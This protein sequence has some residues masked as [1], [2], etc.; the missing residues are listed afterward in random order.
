MADDGP[1]S[2]GTTE[3]R[4]T[5]KTALR[6]LFS[7]VAVVAI[8]AASIW[9]N[10]SLHPG[11]SPRELGQSMGWL[12]TGLF[13]AVVIAFVARAAVQKLSGLTFVTIPLIYALICSW[14]T[15]MSAAESRD[16]GE[17]RDSVADMMKGEGAPSDANAGRYQPLVEY[18]DAHSRIANARYTELDALA[19]SAYEVFEFA[20]LPAVTECNSA[21][22]AWSAVAE[23]AETIEDETEDALRRMPADIAALDLPP[24]FKKGLLE[25]LEEGNA[26][27]LEANAALLTA[28]ADFALFQVDSCNYLA[29][30]DLRFEN[31]VPVFEDEKSELAYERLL[32]RGATI[33]ARLLEATEE[34]DALNQSAMGSLQGQ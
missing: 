20:T 21:E 16:A 10:R 9:I 12:V 14:N 26:A 6:A 31:D 23:L 32:E 7:I 3:T 28:I 13:L 1:E 2:A 15:W 11:L 30:A 34:L 27:A 8:V 22:S 17:L 5:M 4:G 19:T 24:D 29:A 33:D 18:L 25:G